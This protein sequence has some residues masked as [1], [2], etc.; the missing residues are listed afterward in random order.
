MSLQSKILVPIISLF[1]VIMGIS[2]G[3]TYH[4]SVRSLNDHTVGQL[5][6][7][8]KSRAEMIDWWIRGLKEQMAVSGAREEY[9]AVL[10]SGSE[11]AKTR[12]NEALTNQVKVAGFL[13]MSIADSTGLV[14]ASSVPGAAGKI[15]LA[16]REHFQRAMKGDVYASDV[17]IS[18]TLGK[19][20]FNVDAPIRDGEKIIGVVFCVIDLEKFNKEFVDPVTIMESGNVAISDSKGIVF[21]HKDRSLVMEMNLNKLDFGREMLK[22]KHGTISYKFENQQ[23]TAFVETCTNMDWMVMVT[24]PQAEILADANRIAR[25]NVIIVLAGFLVTVLILYLVVR[26]VV[27]PLAQAAAGIDAGADQV[28]SAAVEVSSS[29][30][31]SAEGASEQAAS[32]EQTSAALEEMSSMTRQNAHNSRQAND[33]MKEARQMVHQANE[34]MMQLT[35]SMAQISNAG[36]ETSKIVKTIDEIAFQTNLLAL[37]AAVEAARAGEAG[38]GFAVVA[39]EVRN[40]AL[41]AAEAARNTSGLIECTIQ[42]VKEG[43][44]KVERTNA[45]FSNVEII[46]DKVAGLIS[47]I[48]AASGEQAQGIEQINKSVSHMDRIVQTNSTNSEETAAASEELRAQARVMKDFAAGLITIIAGKGK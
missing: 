23:R 43:S 24:V 21:A 34:S 11:E 18:K 17:M 3:I 40:L 1:S 45:D 20:S 9:V 8:A 39:E 5:E 16:D 33:L 42:N 10:K 14:R 41:R 48:S 12:A 37:N 47:E 26:S 27:R 22:L 36:E 46:T 28:A 30:Q 2:V 38:A 4:F 6:K 29:S 7:L 25:I 31:Q 35:A 15:K 44:E 19:P 32:I 13:F